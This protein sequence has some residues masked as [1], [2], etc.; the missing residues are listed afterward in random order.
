LW[1]GGA[2]MGAAPEQAFFVKC[3]EENNPP[4]EREQGRLICDVGIA[5]SIPFEFVVLRIGRTNNE[6]E[7]MEST[8]PIGGR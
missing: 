3:D 7:I 4:A 8:Q 5:P 2:L 1:E 6:F